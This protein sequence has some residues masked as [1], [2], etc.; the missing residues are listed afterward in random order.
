MNPISDR[1][2]AAGDVDGFRRTT[3]TVTFQVPSSRCDSLEYGPALAITGAS[4]VS[5]DVAIGN[6]RGAINACK[7]PD[8]QF[9]RERFGGIEAGV[10]R[11]KRGHSDA[12][13]IRGVTGGSV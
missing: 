12:E 7:G 5:G 10:E 8:P 6:R 2:G 9:H 13:R 1:V 3:A 4:V 11:D